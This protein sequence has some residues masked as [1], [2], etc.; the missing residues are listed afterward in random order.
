M[1]RIQLGQTSI[2]FFISNLLASAIGF[3][4]SLYIARN[5][6]AEPL[7]IYN[8]GIGLVA[9]LGIIGRI[10]I[11][12][13][14]SKR[15]S[16][17]DEQNEYAIAGTLL[18]SSLFVILATG[19]LLF[20][21][22]INQYVEYSA[23]VFILLILFASLAYGIVSSLL[24]GY[25]LV[26]I[27]GIL[28]T[29]RTAGRGIIQIIAVIAGLGAA[30][31]FWGH[32]V[33][34]LLVVG[35]GLYTVREK[36]SSIERPEKRHFQSLFDFAKFSWLGNLQS[37]MFNYTDIL[38]LGFFVSSSLIGIYSIAWN[39]AQFLI[40][41]S[42]AL[43][44]TLFPEISELSAQ[45]DQQAAADIVEQSLAYGGLFLIPGVFGG[46][47]LGERI[48]QIYGPEFT[49][50]TAVL[51]V[52]IV[53]NLFMGYQNQLLNGLNAINRPDLS[54]R[55]NVVFVTGNISFNIVLIYLYGWIGAAIATAGS[56]AISLVLSYYYL[57][58]VISFGLPKAEILRQGLAA[59]VMAVVVYSGL[60][61]ENS[62]R[63]VR[64][65]VIIVLFLV[66]I[67]AAVYFVVLLGLSP[68]FRKTVDRNIPFTIPLVSL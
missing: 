17:G 39:V 59:A 21:S 55:V 2:I 1:S 56:T 65:N 19:I 12:G 51:L 32:L 43:S 13:A 14:I 45:Q 6:G 23:A 20:R 62:Y 58:K 63:L 31:L 66:G 15:I 37:R 44:S 41:F 11:S 9:W 22:Y 10:G 26:H 34:I 38:V 42:G 40:L 30:G 57:S 16:E 5:I 50:G 53:A 35:I 68:R 61:F 67:G 60:F 46:G 64:H 18:I 36:L 29:V 24:T 25:H 54:F 33:G 49:Q 52:L 8:V 28:S 48:L 27:N 4:A 3:V 47:I 7:G